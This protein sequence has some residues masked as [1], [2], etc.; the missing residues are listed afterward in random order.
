MK[1]HYVSAYAAEFPS[2]TANSIH[3]MKMCEAFISIDMDVVLYLRGQG[4]SEKEVLDSY[5][6][7]VPVKIIFLNSMI[8]ILNRINYSAKA[9]YHAKSCHA[10]LIVS[11]SAIP[12]WFADKFNIDFVFDAHGPISERNL[13]ERWCFKTILESPRFKRMTFNSKAMKTWYVDNDLTPC[14]GELIVAM[15]GASTRSAGQDGFFIDWPGKSNR[16]QIGYTGHLYPG[17]GVDLILLCAERLPEVDFHFIG[18]NDTD[19]EY[20]RS[21]CASKNVYFHGYVNP[22]LVS[23]YRE[24]CDVLLAPYQASG[25][26]VSG[27][28]GDS[29][30]YMNPIKVIEYMSSGKAIIASDLPA[31]RD[32]LPKGVAILVDPTDTDGWVNAIRML[33]SDKRLYDELCARAKSS[34]GSGYTWEARARKLAGIEED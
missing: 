3:V 13:V 20:W 25:V 10:D 7:A 1:I 4:F 34:F 15:N 22:G 21:N 19:I 6:I 5:G 30:K 28:K 17:R 9:V 16:F 11:R 2:R 23:E 29:S 26:T 31:I 32:C 12:C 14:D 27:G 18:G 24:L 33:E 8:P